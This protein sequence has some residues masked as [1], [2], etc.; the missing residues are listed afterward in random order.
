MKIDFFTIAIKG[1][2]CG[3]GECARCGD[4]YTGSRPRFCV[5]VYQIKAVAILDLF[6]GEC[7]VNFIAVTIVG[8]C[9]DFK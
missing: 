2:F 3:V 7:G 5:V 6:V 8:A 9:V 4:A 1:L